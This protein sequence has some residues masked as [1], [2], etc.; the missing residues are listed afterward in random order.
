[1]H[2]SITKEKIILSSH[3]TYPRIDG[4]VEIKSEPYEIWTPDRRIFS[5]MKAWTQ[6][7]MKDLDSGTLISDRK[8]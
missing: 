2:E 6:K 1:M 8:L 5:A 3:Q 4:R 7:L